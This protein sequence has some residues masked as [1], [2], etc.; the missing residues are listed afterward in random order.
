L[1]RFS[2]DRT[3]TSSTQPRQN[4]SDG[5]DLHPAILPEKSSADGHRIPELDGV[6]GLAI[7]LVVVYQQAVIE[8]PGSRLLYYVSLPPHIMWSGVDL[9]F[10]LTGFLIGGILLDHRESQSYYRTFY[11]RRIHRIFPLY[12]LM[13]ALLFAGV[14]MFPYSPLFAGT[15]AAP[16]VSALRSELDRGFHSRSSRIGITW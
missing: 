8:V 11:A 5:S 4:L 15:M 13:I 14:W 6:R 12:Y 9:F 10:V 7:A 3:V 16:D 1:R 2:A